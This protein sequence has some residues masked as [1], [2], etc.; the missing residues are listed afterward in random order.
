MSAT[1][2]SPKASLA[3]NKTVLTN[4]FAS[5]AEEKDVPAVVTKLS[6]LNDK[7]TTIDVDNIFFNDNYYTNY[8][9]KL[10][11]NNKINNIIEIKSLGKIKNGFDER[12]FGLEN[13]IP[14]KTKL[15]KHIEV[16]ENELPIFAELLCENITLINNT[17][18]LKIFQI[19][20][21]IIQRIRTLINIYGGFA[22]YFD[23]FTNCVEKKRID[24]IKKY[25]FSF[26]E[27]K[28]YILKNFFMLEAKYLSS[29][30]TILAEK[31]DIFDGTWSN[32]FMGIFKIIRDNGKSYY[33]IEY[34][35]DPFNCGYI[36]SLCL[37]HLYLEHLGNKKSFDYIENVF[38]TKYD[39]SFNVSNYGIFH[40]LKKSGIDFISDSEIRIEYMYQFH[41]QLNL[42][43]KFLVESYL[44]THLEQNNPYSGFFAK[45]FCIIDYSYSRKFT[46][47]ISK[48]Y[49]D[50][51]K[52]SK[53][54]FDEPLFETY[55]SNKT[56]E[57]FNIVESKFLENIYCIEDFL[58]TFF[59]FF[60]EFKNKM[61]NIK[62]NDFLPIVLLKDFELVAKNL[63]CINCH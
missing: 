17:R 33:G 46:E 36:E 47:E 40:S 51:F 53:N 44:Y 50:V 45:L 9:N 18:E 39:S 23:K 22:A 52:N 21:L 1:N 8:V 41:S 4:S 55:I 25:I 34:F 15:R 10:L 32:G 37:N 26:Y 48:Q 20:A 42:F 12:L 7:K 6:N 56:T 3:K 13:K 60:I 38:N 63:N 27:N 58:E 28:K 54:M 31:S 49:F 14:T 16:V 43:I 5:L 24:K 2:N 61:T 19:I 30:N 35:D 62:S 11:E 57:I 59:N 29:N